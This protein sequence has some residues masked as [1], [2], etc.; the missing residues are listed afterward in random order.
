MTDMPSLTLDAVHQM[1]GTVFENYQEA[2]RLLSSVANGEAVHAE[3]VDFLRPLGV[4]V[5]AAPAVSANPLKDK[6]VTFLRRS[7]GPENFPYREWTNPIKES[8]IAIIN[9]IEEGVFE[10][11]LNSTSFTL[12]S[13]SLRYAAS[14][15][16]NGLVAKAGPDH[17][18]RAVCIS[19]VTALKQEMGR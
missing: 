4:H 15:A 3:I 16:L 7:E 14:Q 11:I 5:G 17:K 6:A 2:V 18:D 12:V 10:A 13:M 8:L 19:L 1:V 9:E